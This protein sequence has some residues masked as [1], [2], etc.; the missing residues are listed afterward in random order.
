MVSLCNNHQQSTRTIS[1]T[2]TS[3]WTEFGKSMLLT[4][5]AG[6]SRVRPFELF[7]HA[8]YGRTKNIVY[9]NAL[10]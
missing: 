5:T 1:T 7:V 4:W 9:P 2:A 8:P 6:C 10:Q 3:V